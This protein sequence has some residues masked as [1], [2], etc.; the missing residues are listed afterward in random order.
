MLSHYF[1]LA[2]SYTDTPPTAAGKIGI[3]IKVPAIGEQCVL[4]VRGSLS[5]VDVHRGPKV[6]VHA[7]VTENS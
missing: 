2:N 1:Y 4:R 7:R 3:C 6:P 5:I